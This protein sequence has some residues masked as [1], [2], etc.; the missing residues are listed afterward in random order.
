MAAT[1]LEFMLLTEPYM[2]QN[3]VPTVKLN[4]PEHT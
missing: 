2:K 1:E 3:L 4:T